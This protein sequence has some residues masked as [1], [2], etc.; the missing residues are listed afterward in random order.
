MATVAILLLVSG[1][2]AKQAQPG[3][4]QATPPSSSPVASANYSEAQFKRDVEAAGWQDTPPSNNGGYASALQFCAEAK[5]QSSDEP[6]RRFR[7]QLEGQGHHT[8]VQ[9]DAYIN[10]AKKTCGFHS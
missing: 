2:G 3:G 1:C 10:A 8:P 7:A 4:A 6:L 5:Q 9:L